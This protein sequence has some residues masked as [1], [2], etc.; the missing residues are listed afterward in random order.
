MIAR[1][2]ALFAFIAAATQAACGGPAPPTQ[3]LSEALVNGSL[4][5]GDP[6]VV[7]LIHRLPASRPRASLA[8]CSGVLIA[9]DVVLTAAHCVADEHTG[10]FDV[11][12]G[13][14]LSEGGDAIPVANSTVH[15]SYVA[16]THAFDVAL[17]RL[18]RSSDAVPLEIMSNA[19]PLL[20]L[21]SDVRAVGFGVDGSEGA[22][23]IDK[24]TGHMIV[25]DVQEGD[26][27]CA[28]S[29]AMTCTGDSGGPILAMAG[30][31]HEQLVGIT[32]YGDPG[33]K[34]IAHNLRLDRVQDDFVT[35]FVQSQS[36]RELASGPS[37]ALA[38]GRTS[39]TGAQAFALVLTLLLSASG[40][41]RAWADLRRRVRGRMTKL[42]HGAYQ[43]QAC[44]GSAAPDLFAIAGEHDAPIAHAARGRDR[45]VY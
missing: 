24:R 38:Q 22:F 41:L 17:L 27:A 26:F 20:S 8:F 40:R 5:S 42:N 3:A 14:S 10:P 32:A 31:E 9:S 15:P 16:A 23:P 18:V 7:A 34:E 25:T 28:P 35:P 13:S 44:E 33:C 4:A 29:L 45:V 43:R 12:F 1:F 30:Q 39:T 11:F 36:A 2:A 37:C 6:A 21:G 19:D